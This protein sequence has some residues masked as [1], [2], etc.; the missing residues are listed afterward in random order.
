MV[1]LTTFSP[2]IWA[3]NG[4][5]GLTWGVSIM[6]TQVPSPPGNFSVPETVKRLLFLLSGELEFG[7]QRPVALLRKLKEKLELW[8]QQQ[9]KNLSKRICGWLITEESH[10]VQTLLH[11]D[12]SLESKP[13]S[14]SLSIFSGHFL[15]SQCLCSVL[16]SIVNNQFTLWSLNP[17]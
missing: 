1:I 9:T 17:Y 2:G 8:F 15:F 13:L 10:E 14:Y 4:A 6:V 11:W 16:I 3:L 12:R 7:S 5:I